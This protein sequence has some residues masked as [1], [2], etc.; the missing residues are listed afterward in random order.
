MRRAHAVDAGVRASEAPAGRDPARRLERLAALSHETT[1]RWRAS[2]RVS[3]GWVQR[4][5]GVALTPS[6]RTEPA[7]AAALRA[8]VASVGGYAWDGTGDNPYIGLL[9]CADAIVV[10]EDS[11]SM[12]SEAL[13]TGK[14]GVRRD[15]RPAGRAAS[16]PFR[17]Q[18]QRKG[19][20]RPFDGTLRDL[21]L[22][23]ARRHGP[24]CPPAA[25]AFWLGITRKAPSTAWVCLL[26]LRQTHSRT[27][28]MPQTHRT[29]ML[30]VGSG[31]AGYTAAIYATRANLSHPS[32]CAAC[33]PAASFRSPPTSR[34]S[35]ASTSPSRAR[36]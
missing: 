19:L 34:I 6:R 28:P 2:R 10:T 31:P 16:P 9:A 1:R 36:G 32:W 26:G 14:A 13:S 35:P 12:T 17:P 4:G 33:S 18:M 20:T 24:C 11:V 22:R 23:T 21:G 3:R 29:K 27:N 30:I 25:R 15:P 7:A 8:A 5:C